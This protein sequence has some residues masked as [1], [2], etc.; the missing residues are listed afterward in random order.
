[1]MLRAAHIKPTIF[2]L[3]AVNAIVFATTGRASEGLDALAWF[4]L[5]A[6]FEIETRRPHWTRIRRYAVV[7]GLLRLAATAGVTVA[8]VAYLRER[9]WIDAANAWLWIGVVIV[10]EFDVRAP[11]LAARWQRYL[12]GT[13]IVLYVAL[14]AVALTWFALGEWLDGY[15]AALWIAAFAL[16][17]MD[18]LKLSSAAGTESAQLRS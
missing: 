12:T 4:A 15:D 6:L 10:L 3:L 2:A 14:A 1:M 7:L 13:S 5:L 16:I 11:A 17:E 18:L 9:E 8:A